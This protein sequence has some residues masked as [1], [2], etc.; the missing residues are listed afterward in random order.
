MKRN[1]RTEK[2]IKKK[3]RKKK[4]YLLK[5]FILVLICTGIYFAVHIEYFAVDGIAVAGNNEISDE[6]IIKLSKIKTGENLFDVHPWFAQRRIKKNLYIEDVNVDRKLPNKIV[7]TVKERSGKAQ[8][9]YG[10]KYVVADNDGMVLDITKEAQKVTLVENIKVNKAELKKDI[11]VKETE[12]Y[13]KAMNI[14][15]T[16]ET[17]DLYFKKLSISGNTVNAYIYDGL[18]CKGSYKNLIEC[19]KNGTLKTVVFDLYQKDVESGVINIGSNNYCSF[20]P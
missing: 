4:R 17:G 6:E 1:N 11:E 5:F 18:I 19:M 10:K 16:A 3:R 13:E 20:T 7:I 15:K 12:I 9:S 8:F 2:N 14:I